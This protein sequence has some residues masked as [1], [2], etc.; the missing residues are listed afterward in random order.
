MENN[1]HID[2]DYYNTLAIKASST[3][4]DFRGKPNA[5][6]V[7]F[8]NGLDASQYVSTKITINGSMLIIEHEPITNYGKKMYLYFP[9]VT[10]DAVPYNA[11]DQMLDAKIGESLEVNLN[12]IITKQT[13]CVYKA[14]NIAVFNVPIQVTSKLLPT[15]SVK[16]GADCGNMKDLEN[17]VKSLKKD[18]DALIHIHTT[19][20][21]S[22][23]GFREGAV[24]TTSKESKTSSGTAVSNISEIYDPASEDAIKAAL[25]KILGADKS[26]G[27]GGGSGAVLVCDALPDSD[28]KE[29]QFLTVPMNANP[30]LQM[31][32]IGLSYVL[33][34]AM[35]IYVVAFITLNAIQGRELPQQK[36]FAIGMMLSFLVAGI[37][38]I[39]YYY[40]KDK[41]HTKIILVS[42]ITAIF[43]GFINF[44]YIW[45][46]IT[47][48]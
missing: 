32:S 2:Y 34:M 18:I 21:G 31:A 44:V 30:E 22:K 41:K 4:F 25:N 39:V 42:G 40:T 23:E 35:L 11:I 26:G 15:V 17:Q 14:S 10:D 5:P 16:E 19:T 6:N 20:P 27:G 3:E 48:A 9:L 37:I 46:H 36:K 33:T 43:T 8:T 7:V 45:R 29:A 24:G 38:P 28:V 1:K 12:T 47:Q 13:D